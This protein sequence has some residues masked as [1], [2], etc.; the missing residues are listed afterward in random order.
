MSAYGGGNRHGL[1]PFPPGLCWPTGWLP[2]V[3]CSSVQKGACDNALGIQ[4]KSCVRQGWC[5]TKGQQTWVVI[6]V[7]L[8]SH[9]YSLVLMF[10]CWSSSSCCFNLSTSAKSFFPYKVIH[11]QVL[12][13]SMCLYISREGAF[14]F[15]IGLLQGSNEI[16][17]M[18]YLAQFPAYS[19]NSISI[20]LF[21]RIADNH[22]CMHTARR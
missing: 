11:S 21:L 4:D 18:K 19:N 6:S 12:E 3:G 17:Q 20:I 7:L 14:F 10:C 2:W 22:I 8:L 13:S 16:M 5:H 1:P 15:L 9:C